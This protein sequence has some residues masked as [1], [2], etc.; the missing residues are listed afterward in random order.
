MESLR[1]WWSRRVWWQKGL[2][3][4]LGFVLALTPFTGDDA[5]ELGTASPPTTLPP[6]TPVFLDSIRGRARARGMLRGPRSEK[7]GFVL[8]LPVSKPSMEAGVT[9]TF[10]DEWFLVV[11]FNRKGRT[12]TSGT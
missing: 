2:L 9:I 5:E 11:P 1:G 3:I 12:P 8:V 4:L 10:F 6:T 7:E